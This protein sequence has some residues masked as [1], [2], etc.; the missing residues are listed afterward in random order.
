MEKYMLKNLITNYKEKCHDNVGRINCSSFS[1]RTKDEVEGTA[2]HH[3]R[4]R[5][6]SFGSFDTQ[7]GILSL[8]GDK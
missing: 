2:T 5:R 3:R 7:E 8:I 4:P 1:N 6:A